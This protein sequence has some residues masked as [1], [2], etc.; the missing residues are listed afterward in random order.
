MFHWKSM[1]HWEWGELFSSFCGE[2]LKKLTAMDGSKPGSTLDF[3]RLFEVFPPAH[4]LFKTAAFDQF[5]K[6]TNCFLN[7]LFVPND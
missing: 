3:A 4:F 6:P 2:P 7:G 1:F 5:T